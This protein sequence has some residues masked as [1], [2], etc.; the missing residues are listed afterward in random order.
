VVAI[1]TLAGLAGAFGLTSLLK[2]MLFG[3]EA[4]DTATFIAV[5]C[6]LA[7]VAL[8]AAY[9]PARRASRVAPAE[10]LRAD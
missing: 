2:S 1:G 4:H 6:I 5:P 10:A 3:V 8:L 9:L 7:A